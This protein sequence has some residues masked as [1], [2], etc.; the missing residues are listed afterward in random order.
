MSDG[1]SLAIFAVIV[2]A[3]IW[4]LVTAYGILV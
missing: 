4:L 1:E 3:T 2:L